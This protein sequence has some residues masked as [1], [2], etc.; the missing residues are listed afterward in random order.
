MFTLLD[1]N[2]DT[3]LEVT[4]IMFDEKNF[5]MRIIELFYD[6]ISNTFLTKQIFKTRSIVTQKY[7]V[8]MI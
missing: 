2:N 3:F 8:H 4:N 5:F 6:L 7:A 1:R